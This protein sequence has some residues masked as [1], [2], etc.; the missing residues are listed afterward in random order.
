LDLA[1]LAVWPAERLLHC[2][3]VTDMAFR[4]E[5]QLGAACIVQRLKIA[6]IMDW[7]V[8]ASSA[9][10]VVGGFHHRVLL[11]PDQCHYS[12][13]PVFVFQRAALEYF[14]HA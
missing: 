12:L 1:T 10:S 8:N 13:H 3:A 6:G 9:A 2:A 7:L 11:P 5:A 4:P 14:V